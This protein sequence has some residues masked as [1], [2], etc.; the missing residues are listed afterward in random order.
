[1]SDIEG[2]LFS[3]YQQTDDEGLKLLLSEASAIIKGKI[4]VPVDTVRMRE[5][6]REVA[7]LKLSADASK[8]RADKM[9]ERTILMMEKLLKVIDEAGDRGY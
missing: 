2:R 4:N 5:L 1:M 8:M 7:Q 6:E 3:A 9:Q